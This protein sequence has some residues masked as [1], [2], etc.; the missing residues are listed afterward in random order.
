MGVES[1]TG[2]KPN[3]CKANVMRDNIK[4]PVRVQK[5]QENAH[6]DGKL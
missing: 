4:G 3:N 6:K 2:E 1:Q 5:H